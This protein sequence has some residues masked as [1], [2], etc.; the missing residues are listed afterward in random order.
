MSRY[1]RHG[2]PQPRWEGWASTPSWPAGELRTV[3]CQQCHEP[4]SSGY[5]KRRADG[6]YRVVCYSCGREEGA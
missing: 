2:P 6:T 1:R 5:R 4:T 3:E